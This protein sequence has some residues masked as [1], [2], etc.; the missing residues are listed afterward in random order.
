MEIIKTIIGLII[1]VIL[2]RMIYNIT[3]GKQLNNQ[4]QNST[5]KPIPSGSYEWPSQGYCGFDIVGESNYQ[6]ALYKLA[7]P[8]DEKGTD[9]ICKAYLV[10]EDDNPYDNKAVR[11]DIEGMTVGYMDRDTARSFRR[12]LGSKKLTG[13]ITACQATLKGGHIMRDGSKASYGAAL[14]LKEFS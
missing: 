11:V 14:D 1:L 10:P 7:Q 5:P 13:K 2:A 12:R 3:S 8:H 6:A 4:Q 9:K